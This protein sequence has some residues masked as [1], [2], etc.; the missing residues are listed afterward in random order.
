[1][2]AI[3]KFVELKNRGVRR[4]IS[5]IPEEKI[6]SA[7]RP[8]YP[9]EMAEKL[10][11]KQM[12]DINRHLEMVG[13]K[14]EQATSAVKK[15]GGA[16]QV[17]GGSKPLNLVPP[18]LK[19]MAGMSMSNPDQAWSGAGNG[20]LQ[21]RLAKVKEVMKSHGLSLAAASKKIKDEKIPY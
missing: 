6:R 20:K 7:L 11:V 2:N 19:S 13:K 21:R 4:A 9:R 3:Q 14:I 18:N 5:E 8:K 10:Y 15:V 17:Q 12:P 16:Q 1:M